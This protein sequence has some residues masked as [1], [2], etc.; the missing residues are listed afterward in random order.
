MHAG[1]RGA[2]DSIAQRLKQLTLYAAAEGEGRGLDEATPADALDGWEL[3]VTGHSLGGALATLFALDVAPG[4]D[5]ARALPVRPPRS[6]PWFMAA[7]VAPDAVKPR[8]GALRL[9]TLGAPRVSGGVGI[10]RIV[11]SFLGMR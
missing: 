7:G 3:V 6:R 9:V 5:A 2:L 8:F 4:V 10:L 1:F 11:V